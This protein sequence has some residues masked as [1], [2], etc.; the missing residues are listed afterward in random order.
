MHI[1]LHV[2]YLLFLSDF[3]DILLENTY[4]YFVVKIIQWKLSFTKQT[5]RR[6]DRHTDRQTDR[7]TDRQTNRQTD[8]HDMTKP[9]VAF[10]NVEKAHN[11]SACESLNYGLYLSYPSGFSLGKQNRL[12][13]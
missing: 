12:V 10:C 13:R 4:I 9:V 7:R 3:N 11:K 1:V 8:R 6:T 2:K 5:G